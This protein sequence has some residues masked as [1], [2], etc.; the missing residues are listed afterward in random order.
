MLNQQVR[1]TDQQNHI[2]PLRFVSMERLLIDQQPNEGLSFGKDERDCKDFFRG[3]S[4]SECLLYFSGWRCLQKKA[5]ITA[6][7]LLFVALLGF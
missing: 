2:L 1:T 7:R 5:M 4:L 3:S 6:G